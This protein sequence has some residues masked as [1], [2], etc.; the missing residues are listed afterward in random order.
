MGFKCGL[1]YYRV[2][3]F[4]LFF[5]LQ[6]TSKPQTVLTPD[7]FDS[8]KII[9]KGE[10]AVLF[11]SGHVLT[12]GDTADIY[13]KRIMKDGTLIDFPSNQLF[14]IKI[15]NNGSKTYNLLLP[16]GRLVTDTVI[17]LPLKL[18]IKEPGSG[19]IKVYAIN[20]AEPPD[21]LHRILSSPNNIMKAKYSGEMGIK[22]LHLH[23]YFNARKY[24]LDAV[25]LDSMLIGMAY[26]NIACTYALEN[27]T[28][29][30][31]HW[32]K[33]AFENGFDKIIHALKE[34]NDLKSIRNL[35]EF[36][37]IVT[38]SLIKE[39]KCRLDEIEHSNNSNIKGVNYYLISESYLKQADPD[40][41]FVWFEK[42]L[43]NNYCPDAG[44]FDDHLF[45]MI[46]NDNRFDSLLTYYSDIANTINL[47]DD[48]IR[49]KPYLVKRIYGK[50]I[51]ETLDKYINLR[52]LWIIADSVKKMPSQLINCKQLNSLWI[53]N[54]RFA[55]FPVIVTKLTSLK[56]LIIKND[57]FSRIPDDIAGNYN[58]DTL[59]L[60]YDG[61]ISI[62]KSL[63][64]IT[65]LKSLIL[66]GNYIAGLP[67]ELSEMNSLTGLDLS[68]NRFKNIP[69]A[70][71]NLKQLTSL[72]FRENLITVIP[73]QIKNLINLKYLDAALN[74]I[75]LL[76]EE[77]LYLDSLEYLDVS[78]NNLTTFPAGIAK[79]KKLRIL[80]IFGNN[81]PDERIKALQAALPQCKI[82]G[83]EQN[84]FAW[85]KFTDRKMITDTA[86]GIIFTYPEEYKVGIKMSNQRVN[87][88]SITVSIKKLSLFDKFG[89]GENIDSTAD[90]YE[91]Q[92][93]MVD[94][95]ISKENFQDAAAANSFEEN[96]PL[97]SADTTD[98]YF[99][100]TNL[101]ISF[102]RHNHQE[103]LSALNLNGWKG[104][105]GES[106]GVW[107]VV[108]KSGKYIED[109]VHDFFT[110]LA[111]KK[112]GNGRSIIVS[113]YNNIQTEEDLFGNVFSSIRYIGN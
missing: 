96:E 37:P 32:L 103:P 25:K 53:E 13:L 73:A 11:L 106:E 15:I 10:T 17:T 94:I 31:L 33:L 5:F 19:D 16:N 108:T 77:I 59:C 55:E 23:E 93:C 58:L 75:S 98:N 28:L 61:L 100:L 51:P 107:E 24:F 74:N 104:L 30:S 72:N 12:L 76:P 49:Q 21:S 39:R 26:Y 88:T 14:R 48:I 36:K 68:G 83:E 102:G 3:F 45:N 69:D 35:P 20:P 47:P 46:C 57:N 22:K 54:S 50:D 40:S 7:Q 1:M 79:L 101:W 91:E 81:I 64:K 9:E 52:D 111:V 71:F 43:Q 89:D 113:F 18:Y 109:D 86:M 85:K 65:N 80:I 87:D 62:P 8:L 60:S 78:F 44:F 92:N 90:E 42:A 95:A 27:D 4:A 112:M 2:T 82:I 41:F 63:S 99:N 56:S 6:A 66:P 110:A 34:D 105:Y 70:I 38:M 29:N 97:I 67:D 84:T